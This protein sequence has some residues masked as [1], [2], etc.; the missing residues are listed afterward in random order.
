MA[1]EVLRDPRDN[2][3]T[4]A[5]L[6]GA[7]WGELEKPNVRTWE[8]VELEARLVAMQERSPYPAIVNPYAAWD[9]QVITRKIMTNPSAR[10]IAEDGSEIL[11]Q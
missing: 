4:V 10:R 1:I 9:E 11:E 3:I 7:V 6:S 2:S 8:D 5:K